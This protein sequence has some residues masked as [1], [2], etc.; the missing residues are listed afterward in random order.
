MIA[1]KV[2]GMD[3]AR[4]FQHV[5]GQLHFRAADLHGSFS[6]LPNTANDYISLFTIGKAGL[7]GASPGIEI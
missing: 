7:Y 6:L 5:I 4:I 2:E 1:G 3:D